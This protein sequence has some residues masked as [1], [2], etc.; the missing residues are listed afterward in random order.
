MATSKELIEERLSAGARAV[1]VARAHA[2]LIGAHLSD[3]AYGFMPLPPEAIQDL[4]LNQ[5]K[6]M[7]EAGEDLRVA[8]SNYRSVLGAQPDHGERRDLAAARLERMLWHA[9]ERIAE[10]FGPDMLR[11]YG[12]EEPPPA[13]VRALA[14]YT[15]NA[16]ALLRAHPQELPGIFGDPMSTERLA[17]ALSAPVDALDDYLVSFEDAPQALQQALIARDQANEHWMRVWRGVCTTLE[18]IFSLANRAD[19][20]ADIRPFLPGLALERHFKPHELDDLDDR[21]LSVM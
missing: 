6:L 1:R 2:S 5:A 11:L 9:R 20:A 21:D 13:G 14:T 7:E 15:H 4:I 12:M 8:E 17:D 10:S 3:V 18:G 19:L 16:L